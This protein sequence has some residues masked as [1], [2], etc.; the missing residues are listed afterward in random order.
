MSGP[1][2]VMFGQGAADLPG[3][4]GVGEK[5]G[6][7]RSPPKNAE[8]SG[9]S[10]GSPSNES[11]TASATLPSKATGSTRPGINSVASAD[12][13]AGSS[14]A[15]TGPTPARNSVT[16]RMRVQAG[17]RQRS[18]ESGSNAARERPDRSS[19]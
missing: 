15:A 14:C 17:G 8:P 9:R 18:S 16:T 11:R 3:S 7:P 4:L 1:G 12:V 5:M 2:S 10:G 13:E 6:G 19:Q